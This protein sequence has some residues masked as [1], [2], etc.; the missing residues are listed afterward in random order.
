MLYTIEKLKN[1]LFFDIETLPK[2]NNEE[3]LLANGKYSE[4]DKVSKMRLNKPLEQS[5]VDFFS[6]L[7]L[8]PEL[9]RIISITFGRIIF[10]GD[11][12]KEFKMATYSN[13]TNEYK[14]LEDSEKWFNNKSGKDILAGYN[15]KNFDIN[16][17][18]KKY[19]AL[20]KLPSSLNTFFKKP[21]EIEDKIMDIML[22]WKGAGNY[23]ISLGLLCDFLNVD[24]PKQNEINGSSLYKD[25][26]SGKLTNENISSYCESDVMSMMKIA[27]KLIKRNG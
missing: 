4:I 10:E 22:D 12:F 24:N 27:I 13:L 1:A 16:V 5:E 14:I 3:D 19:I 25:F 2:Y 17:L 21:W 20:D 6:T 26:L 15:I 9:N 18:Q 8:I 23:M 7:S 11:S